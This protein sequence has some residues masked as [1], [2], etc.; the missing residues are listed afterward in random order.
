LDRVNDNKVYGSG[1]QI[2]KHCKKINLW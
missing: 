1:F 2:C